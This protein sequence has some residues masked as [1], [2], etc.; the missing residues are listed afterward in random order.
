MTFSLR[1]ILLT[2][3]LVAF[4]LSFL[5]RPIREGGEDFKRGYLEK[6]YWVAWLYYAEELV[7]SKTTVETK[8]EPLFPGSQFMEIVTKPKEESFYRFLGKVCSVLT[9]CLILGGLTICGLWTIADYAFQDDPEEIVSEESVPDDEET[10]QSITDAEL[11][12]ICESITGKTHR[13][14]LV[15]ASIVLSR[16][17]TYSELD[18]LLENRGLFEC[19]KCGKWLPREVED[20][21]VKD[22]CSTCVKLVKEEHSL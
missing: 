14:Y 18:P 11:D 6:F 4:L 17:I 13:D 5:V 10:V 20:E 8:L 22:Y 2:V 12:K 15:V 7:E 16:D 19:D 9:Q 21:V 1:N 3:T